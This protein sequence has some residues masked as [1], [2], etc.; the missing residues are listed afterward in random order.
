[1]IFNFSEKRLINNLCS[2][3]E[4]DIILSALRNIKYKKIKSIIRTD[5]IELDKELH[6]NNLHNT[7]LIYN[8]GIKIFVSK[9][10]N[11][12]CL[13]YAKKESKAIVLFVGDKESKILIVENK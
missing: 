3:E 8:D 1:M 13:Q 7:F 9:K 12:F 5:L 11:R 2:K 4:S 10:Q 6:N